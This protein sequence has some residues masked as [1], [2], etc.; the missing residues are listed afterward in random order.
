MRDKHSSNFD[1]R[2][3]IKGSI[4][5]MA[6]LPS[7]NLFSL[8]GCRPRAS[9]AKLALVVTGDRKSGV[10]E[11]MKILD[12]P[13][14]KGKRVFVKPNFNTSDEFPG[15][16]HNDT[17]TQLVAEI[18][19]REAGEISVGDRSGPEPT[20]KVLENKGIFDLSSDMGF[21]VVNFADLE[22]GDWVQVKQEGFHWEDGF[23]VPRTFLE[24]EYIVST[25]CLKTHGFGGIFTMSLKLSVGVTPRKLMREL[26]GMRKTHM[27]RMI[28]EINTA[29]TPQLIVLDGLEAFVDGGPMEGTRKTANVMIAGTDRVA[30]DAAG[31]AVLKRLGSNEAIM[32]TGIFEQEQIQR[33]VELGLGISGPDSIEFLTADPE[34]RAYA[35]ELKTTLLE[36]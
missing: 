18:Q 17:L 3:F 14:M 32:G 5:G 36:G 7:L 20:Q 27:R 34:S 16:T 31:L 9:K 4:V 33:A 10:R 28:A 6:S 12:I 22:E 2:S 29:Y 19:E 21:N 11:M 23:Y 35:A 24:S 15:S 13:P 1:R 30:L 25:C 8:M 26:H